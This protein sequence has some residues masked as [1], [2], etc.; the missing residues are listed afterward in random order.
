VLNLSLHSFP[1]HSHLSPSTPQTPLLPFSLSYLPFSLLLNAVQVARD[2]ELLLFSPPNFTSS[3]L[4]IPHLFFSNEDIKI[5]ENQPYK[6]CVVDFDD[7]Q[8]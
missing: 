1:S 2:D 5:K 7:I 3:I 8:V 6:S 4:R